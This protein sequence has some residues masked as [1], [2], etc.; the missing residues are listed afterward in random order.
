[1]D[2]SSNSKQ[3]INPKSSSDTEDSAIVSS[4]ANKKFLLEVDKNDKVIGKEGENVVH[5]KG[6]L[7]RGFVIA[8]MYQNL[9]IIQHRKNNIFNGYLD[10][11]CSSHPTQKDNNEEGMQKAIAKTLNKQWGITTGN[12]FY[13]PKLKGKIYYKALDKESKM[14]EHEIS[15]F[16]VSGIKE[17]PKLNLTYSYGYSFIEKEDLYNTSFASQRIFAPWVKEILKEKLL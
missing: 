15:Y 17:P 1:M 10:F 7:H 8:L 9:Y 14:I 12:L 3:S 2:N 16:F 5:S 6:K 11:T 4:T 13:T